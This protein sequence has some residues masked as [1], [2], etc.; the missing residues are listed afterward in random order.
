MIKGKGFSNAIIVGGTSAVPDAVNQQLSAAGVSSVQRLQGE[1]R[2]E[3]SAKIAE[4][5][6]SQ[7]MTANGAVFA[8]GSNFPDALVAGPFAGKNNSMVLLADDATI[9]WAAKY[10][11][12]MSKAFIAGGP[13]AVSEDIANAIASFLN[14]EYIS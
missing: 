13:N 6:K 1:T 9:Q 14:L 4:Y 2:Y 8:T 5:E 12:G 10:K 11:E 3:T 7:D